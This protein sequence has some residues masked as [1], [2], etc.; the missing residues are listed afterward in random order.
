MSKYGD[1]LIVSE[2]SSFSSTGVAVVYKYSS[3]GDIWMQLGG[4]IQNPFST[5]E[6]YFVSTRKISADGKTIIVT[7]YLNYGIASTGNSGGVAVYK[8]LDGN[9]TQIYLYYHGETY[10]DQ[11]GSGSAMCDN[12]ELFAVSAGGSY[13][14]RTH[15]I[16]NP[17]AIKIDKD[18]VS[19]D[20]LFTGDNVT[21]Q[22]PTL[23]GIA[24]NI[25]NYESFWGSNPGLGDWRSGFTNQNAGY[26]YI[27][28]AYNSNY[29]LLLT[30]MYTGGGGIHRRGHD[31]A[32]REMAEDSISKYALH[33]GVLQTTTIH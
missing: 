19:L 17:P 31:L 3:E 20:N 7:D 6:R 23:K 8:Y 13:F 25:A 29:D 10:N 5:D 1:Y 2:Q 28:N 4:N 24:G 12:G 21:L 18:G 33:K 14:V 16:T 30:G 27:D 22:C 15:Q 32:S 9:W 11:L 26:L